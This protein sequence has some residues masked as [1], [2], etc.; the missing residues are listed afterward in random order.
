MGPGGVGTLALLF[1][2]FLASMTGVVLLRAWPLKVLCAAAAFLVAAVFGVG[3]VNRYYGYYDTWSALV[4][5]LKSENGPNALPVQIPLAAG[6]RPAPA[7]ESH[8]VGDSDPWSLR[9]LAL[10]GGASGVQGRQAL[11]VL[12]PPSLVHG[13]L[14]VLLFLHGEPGSPGS[15][16]TGL[17][18]VAALQ[19][20]AALGRI[21]AMAVVLPDI[22]GSVPNQQCLDVT[23]HA[24]L[25]TWLR[26]EVP[27][28]VAAQLD[29]APPGRAWVVAGLSAGGFCAADL[30]LHE[31]GTYAGA[32]EIDGYNEPDLSHAILRK[33]FLGSKVRARRDSPREIVKHWPA[34]RPLPAFWLMA[35]TGNRTDYRDA[36]AF[37]TLLGRRE[38]P[39]F[40][41][42]EGGRHTKPAWI[43]A[44]P[45]ML[46]WAWSTTT[47]HA[48]G[49]S[50]DLPLP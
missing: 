5:D 47:S 33:A 31:P 19:R 28:D 35:G 48:P 32:A 1:V 23:H 39:R 50:V 20:Q 41:T 11:V 18:L 44:L 43:A 30:A 17:Q 42:V 25:A 8:L 46:R 36:V 49:G 27:A 9:R 22:H 16:T 15:L 45:D 40:V 14:P 37:G 7:G 29:V 13:P 10:P 2:A 24:A 12:P 21:G 38:D 34:T 26:T 3:G 6:V 4:S